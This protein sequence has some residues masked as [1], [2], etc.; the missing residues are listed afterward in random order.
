MMF[1]YFLQVDGSVKQFLKIT[2]GQMLK[3]FF[4]SVRL[5]KGEKVVILLCMHR[6]SYL[7]GNNSVV[8]ITLTTIG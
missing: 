4:G 1:L 3:N 2:N 5:V 8:I 7:I 6:N